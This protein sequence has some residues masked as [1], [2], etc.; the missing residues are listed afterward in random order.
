MSLTQTLLFLIF[1]FCL[2]VSVISLLKVK[3]L[4]HTNEGF[5]SSEG[6]LLCLI[7]PTDWLFPLTG[8]GAACLR[9]YKCVCG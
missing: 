9:V 2:R 3:I 4:N 5:D 1:P 8:P 7:T 6:C